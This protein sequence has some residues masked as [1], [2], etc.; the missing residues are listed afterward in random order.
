MAL[1]PP[2]HCKPNKSTPT[3]VVQVKSKALPMSAPNEKPHFD[4]NHCQ[5][6]FWEK[7]NIDAAAQALK[8]TIRAT[9]PGEAKMSDDDNN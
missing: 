9:L 8:G 5:T 7:E 1:Q 2:A 6:I 4:T 3:L